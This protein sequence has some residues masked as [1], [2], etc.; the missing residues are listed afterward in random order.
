MPIGVLK[1]VAVKHEVKGD[2]SF[3][4]QPGAGESYYEI[5]TG[6]INYWNFSAHTDYEK[7]LKK[8]YF[9]ILVGTQSEYYSTSYSR[10]GSSKIV[11][12][13][14]P[15]IVNDPTNLTSEQKSEWSTLGIFSRLNYN[16]AMRYLA[17]VN[18]RADAASRFP[19]D[20]RWGF[21]P[22]FS[23]GWNIAE[24]PFFEKIK[25]KTG[26]DMFKIR[27]SFGSLG[28]RIRIVFILISR[29]CS[30]ALCPIMFLTV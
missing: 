27:G 23:V 28:A 3:N 15:W 11:S 19:T 6:R 9:K 30:Q 13:D 20:K 10:I 8:H 12:D 17:E 21:F 7:Q 25:E 29:R 18:F 4:V 16:Y 22:S 24:E 14:N 2:G 1:D 5:G 26:W